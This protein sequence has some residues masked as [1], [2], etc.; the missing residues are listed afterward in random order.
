[1]EDGVEFDES[2][3][4]NVWNCGEMSGGQDDINYEK[5]PICMDGQPPSI[6]YAWAMGAPSLTLP[7]GVSYQVGTSKIRYLVLQQHY[8]DTTMFKPP[9]E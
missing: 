5:G 9:S 6:V 8:K 3:Y 4:G 2:S 1:M 7:D